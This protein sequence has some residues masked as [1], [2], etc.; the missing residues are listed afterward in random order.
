MTGKYLCCSGFQK[1]GKY[2]GNCVLVVGMKRVSD[3]SRVRVVGCER[4]TTNAN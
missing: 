1:N 4:Y 3:G 2:Y